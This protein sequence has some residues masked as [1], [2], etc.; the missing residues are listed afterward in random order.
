MLALSRRAGQSIIID[1]R[2]TVTVYRV[3]PNGKVILSISAPDEVPVQRKE[4]AERLSAEGESFTPSFKEK[5]S[6]AKASR[7]SIGASETDARVAPETQI[8]HH[9]D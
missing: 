8:G 1:A 5:H 3:Y 6:H 7:T 2:I 9:G 4:I